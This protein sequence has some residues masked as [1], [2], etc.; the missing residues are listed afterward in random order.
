MESAKTMG[1]QMNPV[2]TPQQHTLMTAVPWL[3][4]VL[5]RTLRL[6]F[7]RSNLDIRAL[8]WR[9]GCFDVRHAEVSAVFSLD[10]SP[11]AP[12]ARLIELALRLISRAQ[13]LQLP[14]LVERD[15]PALVHLWPGEHY[16]LLAAMVR[17]L[18]PQ[19]VLEIGT[20]TGLSALAM[21]PNLPANARLTSV[22]VI[23]WNR[24][25]GTFLK[26]S[27]FADGRLQ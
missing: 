10:D 14:L 20:F 24:I 26:E 16:R 3:K 21:L 8:R 13:H 18:Q 25:S 11:G 4:G 7:A 23:P 12:S 6:M 9:L 17:E 19:Q 22:D 27:D 1:Q 5:R 2:N 15:A